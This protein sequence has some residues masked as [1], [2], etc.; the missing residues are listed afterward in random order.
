MVNPNLETMDIEPLCEMINIKHSHQSERIED[1][2][3]TIEIL[4]IKALKL[5]KKDALIKLDNISRVSIQLVPD[6]F[7]NFHTFFC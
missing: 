3:T 2:Q 1:L 7:Y 6:V 5:E 4:K